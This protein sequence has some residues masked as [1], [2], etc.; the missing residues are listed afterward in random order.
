MRARGLARGGQRVLSVLKTEKITRTVSI[1]NQILH[2]FFFFFLRW[3][4]KILQIGG[5]RVP[6]WGGWNLFFWYISILFHQWIEKNIYQQFLLLFTLY[7]LHICSYLCVLMCLSL[8]MKSYLSDAINVSSPTV[9]DLDGWNTHHF[10]I[11]LISHRVAYSKKLFSICLHKNK[12]HKQLKK[13]LKFG[14]NFF[15]F[16][17]TFY[18]SKIIKKWVCYSVCLAFVN[19]IKS[20]ILFY[21]WNCTLFVMSG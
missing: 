8:L 20:S 17:S 11:N 3:I 16:F 10:V 19:E 9:F 6:A 14:R 2:N 15:A 7:I 21:L 12:T 13:T 1:L 5:A 18:F 4:L